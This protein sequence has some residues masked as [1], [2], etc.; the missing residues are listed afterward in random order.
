MACNARDLRQE[1]RLVKTRHAHVHIEDIG[2]GALLGGRLGHQVVHITRL[3]SRFQL[4]LP[5]R[6]DALADDGDARLALGQRHHLLR[7][8]HREGRTITQVGDAERREALRLALLPPSNT[9][10]SGARGN[11]CR[12]GGHRSVC[13]NGDGCNRGERP[14][15]DERAQSSNMVGR[16][17]AAA[18][19]DRGTGIHDRFHGLGKFVRAHVEDC[20]LYTSPS[21]RDA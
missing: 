11:S 12:R 8:G 16:R 9:G 2:A 18:A 10:R 19:Y 1:R 13:W 14:H 4:L 17:A 3:Q 21:P 20:L 6:V 7:R 5:R 15:I